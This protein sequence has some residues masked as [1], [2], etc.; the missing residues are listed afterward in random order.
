MYVRGRILLRFVTHAFSDM[1]ALQRALPVT[2]L[3]HQYAGTAT[4]RARGGVL[5][6]RS[7]VEC[8]HC[9]RESAV[10]LVDP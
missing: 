2:N 7:V 1:R 4:A 6:A 10:G 8:N 5:H 3:V 9:E